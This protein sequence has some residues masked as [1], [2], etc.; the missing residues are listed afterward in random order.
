MDKHKLGESMKSQA[1]RKAVGNDRKNGLCRLVTSVVGMLLL[2]GL[3]LVSLSTDG[4]A[5]PSNKLLTI[6]TSQEFDSLNQ[7]VTTAS[8]AHYL[9]HFTNR[10]LVQVNADWKWE[11]HLCVE[12]P[13]RENGLVKILEEGGRKKLLATWKIKPEAVWSDG[14]PVTA[15]D[16]KFTWQVG[17]DNNVSVGERESYQRVE[18]IIPDE[19]DPKTFVM[20]FKE[21]RYDYYYLSS[22]YVMPSHIEEPIYK[23]HKSQLGAYEKNSA[24][25]ADPTRLGLANGPYM[26]KE[27]KLGSHVTFVKNPKW[28]GKPAAIETITVKLIPNTQ[29]LEANLISGT[30]DM[31]NELGLSFDQAIALENR[32]KGDPALS[33]EFKVQFEDSIVYEHIE[34]NME[35]PILKD[36]QVRKALMHSLDRQKLVDA[37]FQNKQKVAH[38]FVH[39]RDV[40]FSD[41]VTR[42]DYDPAKAGKMLD[43]AGWKMGARGYREKNGQKLSLN[44]MTTAGNKSRELVQ[45]FLQEQLKKVGVELTVNN[46]PARVLFGEITPKRQF[47]ALVMFAQTSTP[48]NVPA[49]VM[50][51]RQIPT[52]ENGYGGQNY[53]AWKNKR[54]DE[55][56]DQA[57]SELDPAQRKALM[58][59]Q[60]KIFS[61]DLPHFPLYMRADVVVLPAKLKGYRMTGHLVLPSSWAEE[62][63]F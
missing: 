5:E 52:K 8:A 40:F 42:Y 3:Q 23:K 49:S 59:E 43:E 21:V 2:F 17:L 36:L 37:L 56:L 63:S 12:I 61:E 29:T 10:S 15:K 20:K 46:V 45:V 28:Y 55:I 16:F 6:G 18:D 30:I 54:V 26:V 7:L 57:P 44:I 9:A 14:T 25:V 53:G 35:N 60:Q 41:Q 4:R 11:C 13:T 48:E 39:P 58:A 62:W 24:F 27:V 32:L 38:T 47:P 31:I 34:L 1:L 19:K 22:F 33:K 51:S 50:H